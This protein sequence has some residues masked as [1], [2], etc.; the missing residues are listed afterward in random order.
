MRTNRAVVE[1][2]DAGAEHFDNWSVTKDERTLRGLAEFCELGPDDDL[3]DV[4][5]GTGAMALHGARLVRT[6]TGVDISEGMIAVARRNAAGRGLDNASFECHDVERL[7]LRSDRFSAV[8]S[9]SAF[10]HMARYQD[11]FAGMVRCCR[12]G[13]LLCVQD[14]MAYGDEKK[15]RY[16]EEMERLIDRSHHLTY[17]KREF[18]GLFKDNGVRVT[19]LFE[20]ESLLDFHDYVEHVAQTEESRA[21]IGGLLATGL[22]DPDVATE[23]TWHE[24]RLMWRR[25]VCTIRGRKADRT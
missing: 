2:F 18:F 1:Q 16:F 25:K 15:D 8:V 3:L 23:F 20:S 24:D 7:G 21:R 14:V 19:G 13:G 5:C 9:R 17:G 22:A 6:V 11:V 12:P 10:H 4:A